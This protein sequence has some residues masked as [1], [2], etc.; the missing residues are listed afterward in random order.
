MMDKDTIFADLKTSQ[1]GFYSAI[2]LTII[3]II[4]FGFA[5]TAIPI[6]GAN[7]PTGCIGYP[8]LNTLSQY[9]KDFIWMYFA[10]VLIL[11]YVVLMVSIHTYAAKNKKIFSQIGVSFAIITA[12]ILLI[13][14]YL[15]FSV[16]PISLLNGET[17]GIPLFIQYNPHGIFLALEE[18][19]YM[20]MSLSFLFISAVFNKNH[21]EN[22]VRWVFI[23]GFLLSIISFI[24]ISLIY[25][26]D[27]MDRFEVAIIGIDW[28]VLLVNGILIGIVFK[29]QMKANQLSTSNF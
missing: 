22:A 18:L 13:D 25:G 23:I 8:Y 28:L 17:E 10:V 12:A 19:G 15:Q 27:R 1:V 6:S 9:P 24:L 20:T 14:Y 11:S 7:C 29:R 2:F 4:T 16:I 5:L 3:T 26:L 21:L